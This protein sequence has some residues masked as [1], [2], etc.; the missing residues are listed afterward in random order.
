M[1]DI[2]GI[3][4]WRT[5][6]RHSYSRVAIVDYLRLGTKQCPMPGR[7]QLT[8]LSGLQRNED[9]EARVR[10]AQRREVVATQMSVSAED[11]K[12]VG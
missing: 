5:E 11:D 9:L 2:D 7:G 3:R 1:W 10:A 4:Y 8:S 12:A 6:C